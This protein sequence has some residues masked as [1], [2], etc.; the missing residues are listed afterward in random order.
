MILYAK[1]NKNKSDIKVDGLNKKYPNINPSAGEILNIDYHI[2]E[3]LKKVWYDRTKFP[4]IVD[5]VKAI[6]YSERQIYRL[7]IKYKLPNRR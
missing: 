2:G 6:G 1:E 5:I 4:A 3:I 7:A